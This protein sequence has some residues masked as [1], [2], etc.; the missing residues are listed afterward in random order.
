MPTDDENLPP[1]ENPPAIRLPRGAARGERAIEIAR[2][3]H[4]DRLGRKAR[5]P[6]EI[7]WHGWRAVLGRTFREIISDRIS[8]VAAGCAFYATL[9]LFPAISM[10]I[11]IYGLLFD[12]VTVEPQLQT[13]QELLPPEAYSLIASRVHQLVTQKHALGIGLIVSILITFWSA[14]TGTK[15]VISALNVAYEEKE[16]RT[17]LQFQL[18]AFIMTLC[19]MFGGVLCIAGL[20]FLPAVLA[21]LGLSTYTW[22]LLRLSSMIVLLAFI[23]LS[24]S[25]LYRFGPCRHAA[26]WEWITPGSLLA[27]ILWLIASVLLSYYIGHIASYDLYYGPL[28]AVVCVMMWFYVSVYAM[29]LGAELNS[30]LELQTVRDS[31]E[32]PPKPL[33]RRGAYVAD[34]VAED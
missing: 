24:L 28:G 29:L 10:L 6:G 18:T 1:V 16:S 34:H 12:P 19:A 25:A 13:L 31:T 14:T 21:F 2:S 32:G 8:L 15:A 5:H 11:F 30:E 23:V 7:P 26:K 27:T 9:A 33:G 20:V 4:A 22:L 17:I 3:A